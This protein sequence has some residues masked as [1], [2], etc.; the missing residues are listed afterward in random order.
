MEVGIPVNVG[1]VYRNSD[2]IA[3]VLQA[4]EMALAFIFFAISI[5]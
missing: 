2:C 1:C 5:S 3:G 4:K